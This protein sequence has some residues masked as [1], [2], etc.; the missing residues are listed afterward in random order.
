VT[1]LHFSKDRVLPN[2]CL[3]PKEFWPYT[4]VVLERIIEMEYSAGDRI[5]ELYADLLRLFKRAGFDCASDNK[6]AFGL[7]HEDS[8]AM[9]Y[10]G[11]KDWQFSMGTSFSTD[12]NN[13]KRVQKVAKTDCPSC[14]SCAAGGMGGAFYDACISEDASRP[15]FDISGRC[16]TC[17]MC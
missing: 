12:F 9:Y 2:S 10:F 8:G 1:I 11:F 6:I 17:G 15:G 13:L 16:M 14:P 5:D 3:Q 4:T 7:Q